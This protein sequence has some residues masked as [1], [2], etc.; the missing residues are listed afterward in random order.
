MDKGK[1]Y[2]TG[3]ETLKGEFN[4]SYY[5]FEK[6]P[7][8]LDWLGKFL[9][10]VFEIE[11][12]EQQAKYVFERID[13]EKGN[14]IKDKIYIKN[15]KKMIDIH[16]KYFPQNPNSDANQDRIDIFYGK[17]RIYL[18]I[19]TSRDKRDRAGSFMRKSKKWIKLKKVEEKKMPV[20]VKEIKSK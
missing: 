3:N 4:I 5:I 2:A 1:I 18:T 20:Y 14:W 7:D 12:G 6:N 8:F 13:D 15:V 16:E 9:T 11:N 10:E 19:R 17:N